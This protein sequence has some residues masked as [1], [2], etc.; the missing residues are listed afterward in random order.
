MV[1][2]KEGISVKENAMIKGT[3]EGACTAMNRTSAK[4]QVDK[5]TRPGPRENNI[6][7]DIIP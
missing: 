5:T 1:I 4:T 2:S 6:F 3:Q 7:F